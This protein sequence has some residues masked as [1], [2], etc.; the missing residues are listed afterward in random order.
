MPL[1]AKRLKFVV[2]RAWIVLNFQ[3]VFS[4]KSFLV[5]KCEQ[6]TNK[7]Y[8]L[9]LTSFWDYWYTAHTSEITMFTYS[10]SY[11]FTISNFFRSSFW[12]CYLY[13]RVFHYFRFLSIDEQPIGAAS[14]AQVHHA[15]L[16]DGQEVAI[17][18]CVLVSKL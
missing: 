6:W 7:F 18:V 2:W 12:R 8:S 11:K 13:F 4:W 3:L 10:F 5:L 1:K 14:I 9:N 17:K 15:V 16:K